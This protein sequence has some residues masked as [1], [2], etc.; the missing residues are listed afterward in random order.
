M[1]WIFGLFLSQSYQVA[2]EDWEYGT[3]VELSSSIQYLAFFIVIGI[4]Q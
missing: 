3:F 2:F 4:S 1:T